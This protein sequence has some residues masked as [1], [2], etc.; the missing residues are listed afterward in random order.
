MKVYWRIVRSTTG[1][2]DRVIGWYTRSDCV[3]AEFH[4]PITDVHAG[5]YFGAQPKGGVHARDSNYLGTVAYD[6]YASD[7]PDASVAKLNTFLVAQTGKPYDMR[8]I[9]NM[10][11]FHGDVTNTKRW[12]C[13]ELVFYA[14][15]HVGYQVLRAPLRQADRITP[16]DLALATKPVLVYSYR[17]K[18]GK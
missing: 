5:A 9:F 6:V 2:Y 17:P 1:F 13:S 4:W 7:I 8:A 18:K 16:R 3:H 11:V 12:F 10:G 14:L 15:A